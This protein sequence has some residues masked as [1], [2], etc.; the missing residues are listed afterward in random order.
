ME[1]A[2]YTDFAGSFLKVPKD[3]EKTYDKLR[4]DEFFRIMHRM[5]CGICVVLRQ[6]GAKDKLD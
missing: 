1:D 5:L 2:Q 4:R 3:Q 6:F